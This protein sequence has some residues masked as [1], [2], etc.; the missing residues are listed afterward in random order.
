MTK[1]IC[2]LVVT[3]LLRFRQACSQPHFFEGARKEF[4]FWGGEAENKFC[5]SCL[6][7][8]SYRKMIAAK[9]VFVRFFV[10]EAQMYGAACDGYLPGYRY[11]LRRISV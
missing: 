1:T 9:M 4:F 10:G 2:L 5:G 11:D 7:W 8:Y 3:I 6:H